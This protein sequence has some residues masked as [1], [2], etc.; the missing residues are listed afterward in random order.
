MELNASSARV[1]VDAAK[2]AQVLP[3][4]ADSDVRYYLVG[5]C[6]R[7]D[8]RGGVLVMATDGHALYC[9]RDP[10][11]SADKETILPLSKRK[12]ARYLKPD[13]QLFVGADDNIWIVDRFGLRLWVSPTGPVDGKFPK[14]DGIIGR[15]DSYKEGLHG[16]FRRDLLLRMLDAS[17][18]SGMLHCYTQTE[19]DGK[20]GK[21][22][23]ITEQDSFGVLMPMRGIP[24]LETVIPEQF[25]TAAPEA[26]PEAAHAS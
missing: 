25:L 26:T 23:F 6:I 1:R 19:V 22:L 9:V 11:G 20:P 24:K 4:A 14:M 17:S 3:Y 15:L 7:P 5:V 18:R 13:Q 10:S 2:L 16:A 12:H 21:L 8:P